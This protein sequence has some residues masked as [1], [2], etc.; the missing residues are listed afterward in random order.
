MSPAHWKQPAV[1]WVACGD[2]ILGS[3]P[4]TLYVATS[5]NRRALIKD[6]Q[7]QGLLACCW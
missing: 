3:L 1:H 2:V 4:F 7:V 5:G 6:Q